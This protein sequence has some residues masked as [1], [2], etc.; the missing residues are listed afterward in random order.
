MHLGRREGGRKR[1]STDAFRVKY[2]NIFNGLQN[3][4][5]EASVPIAEAMQF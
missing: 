4:G 3:A 1:I 5:S 2:F